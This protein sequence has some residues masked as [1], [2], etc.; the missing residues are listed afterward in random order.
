MRMKPNRWTF[1]AALMASLS[2]PAVADTAA[3][4]SLQEIIVTAT[5]RPEDVRAISGAV[6]AMTGEELEQLGAEGMADYLTRTPG[7]VFNASIPG[8]SSVAIRGVSTNTGLDQGEGTTG[9]FINDVPLTDPY[10]S[11]ATP[12]IDTFDVDNVVVLR[13]PQGTLFGS[14]SLGGAINYQAALPNLQKEELRLQG[15]AE[16]TEHGGAGGS[17]KIMVNMPLKENVFAVR[18]VYIYRQDAGYVDNLGT[19]QKDANRTLVRGGRIEALWTPTDTTRLSYL[20]LDQTQDT[21][22]LGYETP[23][24]TPPWEKNSAREPYDFRV[25]LH[26]LR[27]DQDS[28]IGTFTATASYHEKT[29]YSVQ[30]YTLAASG[31]LPGVSPILIIQPATSDGTTFEARLASPA[32]NRFEYLIGV[33]HDTTHEHFVNV[34]EGPGAAA[35]IEAVYGP[36]FG[37]GIGELSAPNDMVLNAT[38]KIVGSESALFGETTFHFNDAWKATLGGR[39][40]ET[41][42]SNETTSYGFLTL[43]TSGSLSSDLAGSQKQSGFLPKGSITWTP[44]KDLMAYALIDKGFRFG[45]PNL[46]TASPG[47][48]VPSQFRS[49]SLVNYEIGTRTT[50]LDQRL[51]LDASVFHIDWSDIQLHLQT[52][53]G[54]N[55]AANA[56]KATIN[57]FEGTAKFIVTEGLTLSGT[58]TYLDAKLAEPFDSGSGQG[59]IPEGST[60]PGASKWQGTAVLGYEWRNLP[61]TPS[62]VL[63]DRYISEAPGNFYTG[64]PQGDYNLAD[65]RFALHAKHL[66]FTAFVDNLADTRGITNANTLP[67]VQNFYVRPRTVGLTVDFRL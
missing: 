27:L 36:I 49:D 15:T 5:K 50:W 13:G 48:S 8:D 4:D 30:D 52:D 29:Q 22:D 20:Y 2:T 67:P 12:D 58:V 32:G 21:R 66:T 16:S 28:S 56:G 10:N 31:L 1:F 7:V 64:L 35:A 46:F 44:S 43:V 40:F 18:A 41:K 55:Y 53:L 47:A 23:E 33:M 11:V 39:A 37:A 62:L 25:L 9:Y 57:G 38:I 59:V 63:A 42:E 60:L 19:G 24:L 65:A 6:T 14:A 54:L 17:G 26:N 61:L 34:L 3:G 45:G 51:Q